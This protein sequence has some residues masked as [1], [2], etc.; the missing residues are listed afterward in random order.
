MELLSLFESRKQKVILIKDIYGENPLFYAARTSST[1]VFNWFYMAQS[2]SQSDYFK[3]RGE[4]N[5]KGQTIEHIVCMTRDPESNIYSVI[6]AR[7]D[8]IDYYGNL[9]I[10]YAL[11]RNDVALV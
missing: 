8:I 9:P 7:P 1:D 4:Q 11:M 2:G 3:A 10:F 6:K 5:Y